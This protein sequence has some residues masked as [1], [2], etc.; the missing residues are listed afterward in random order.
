MKTSIAARWVLAPA[1]HATLYPGPRPLTG[2]HNFR[3]G[4]VIF[5][6]VMEGLGEKEGRE[7]ASSRI[8]P[9]RFITFLPCTTSGAAA[10]EVV[11]AIPFTT[12]I[13]EA[14]EVV[15]TGPFTTSATAAAEVAKTGPFATP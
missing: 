1:L 4:E 8:L 6:Y 15:K 14:A 3:H 13:S 9:R 10:A 5:K 11:T 7:K 12:S 2:R